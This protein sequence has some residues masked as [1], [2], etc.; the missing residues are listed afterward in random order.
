M[1]TQEYF[2]LALSEVQP[3]LGL[4][5]DDKLHFAYKRGIYHYNKYVT[6]ICT[7]LDTIVSRMK[8]SQTMSRQA[9]LLTGEMGSGKTAL[10]A[11]LAHQSKF[12]F[13][14]LISADNYVGFSDS[15]VCASIAKIF[16]DAYK[17]NLSVII[18]DD[19]ERIIG[20]TIGPRFSNAILQALLTCIRRPP[21]ELV[22][23]S[24]LVCNVVCNDV[25]LCLCVL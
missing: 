18:L 4:K 22:L 14:R 6:E 15:S 1:V 12:P 16:S 24:F 11:Y 25:W 3:E 21:S 5:N 20:F 8:R 9:L 13:I 19:I 2:D 17:S 10:A 7:L 23:F